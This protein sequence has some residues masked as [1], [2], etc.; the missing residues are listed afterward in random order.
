VSMSNEVS[1]EQATQFA[2]TIFSRHEAILEEWLSLLD[3]DTVEPAAGFVREQLD[4]CILAFAGWLIDKDPI[5]SNM[6]MLWTGIRPTRELVVAAVV[7]MSLFPEALR[8]ALHGDADLE[9]EMLT[10]LA[11]DFSGGTTNRILR[12]A[13]L[14]INEERWE[15]IATEIESRYEAQRAQRIRRLGVLIEIAHAVSTSQDLDSL[16]EQVHHAATRLAGSDYTEISLLDPMINQ[17]RC[18]VVYSS[19]RRRDDLEQTVIEQGLANEVIRRGHELAFSDYASACDDLGIPYSSAIDDGQQRAWMGA[20]MFKDDQ[21]VGV[22]AVSCPLTSFDQEDLELIAAVARQTGVALENRRL[23][24]TQRRQAAHLSAVNHLAR[25]IADLHVPEQL[26]STATT[27]VHDFFSSSL[28]TIFLTDHESDRLVMRSRRPIPISEEDPANSIPIAPGTIVGAVAH[29]RHP[30]KHDDIHQDVEHLSTPHTESTRSEMAVPIIH[31]GRLYGILDVQSPKVAAFD[32]Q[33]LTTLSTIAD[34]IAIGLENS[35]LLLEEAQRSRE[36]RL[37]L[38]TTRAASASLLLDEVLERLGEG[39]AEAAGATNCLIHLYDDEENFFRP[40]VVVVPEDIEPPDAL[41]G[42]NHILPVEDRYDLQQVLSDSSPLITCPLPARSPGEQAS[43]TLVVPLRTRQRT[44]GLAVIATE[45]ESSRSYPVAQ[46]RLIQGVADSAALAVEN[47][48]LYARAYGL[49]IAEERGRLAQE[50][51]DTLAQGLTAISLQLDLADSYLPTKP[52]KAAKNV[53]R[54]LDLTRQ[55]L[56]EAR[57]SVLDLRAADVHHMSLPDAI[58]QLL[59]RLADETTIEYEFINEGFTS[60]VSARIEV[61]LYRMLEEAL[62][63]ARRHSGASH[64]RVTVRADGEHIS[65]DIED[66]GRGFEPSW[67]SDHDG[68][69]TGFGLLGMRERARIL[70]GSLTISSNLGSGTWLRVTVPF[71]ARA[72]ATEPATVDLGGTYDP[73]P[74][75]R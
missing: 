36:L 47:A 29:D 37:M 46:M 27:L 43:T 55:N 9:V 18:H 56:D 5:T 12:G 71:E 62:E 70:G 50:I 59:R 16:L 26:L 24:E 41:R 48:R 44:L 63:N 15:D 39:L 45:F 28:V 60:R 3:S 73:Y 40:A 13:N 21:I 31:G 51:H 75:R 57:R 38:L 33:D 72:R 32:E 19:G 25:E 66:D 22:I 52:D 58:S 69:T 11:A 65:V 17:L 1:R 54:A 67:V 61:G 42:W 7:S 53:R 23:I 14:E 68:G 64:V 20:P 8:S 2:G 35:R 6:S 49:A 30:I 74:H 10:R 4:A 34:Q